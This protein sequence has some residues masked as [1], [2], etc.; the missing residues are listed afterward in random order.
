[1]LYLP[2]NREVVIRVPRVSAEYASADTLR[3]V[4]TIDLTPIAVSVSLVAFSPLWLQL[5]VSLPNLTAGE[6]RYEVRSGA[7]V[8]SRGLAIVE[9][10]SRGDFSADFDNAFL[11]DSEII[12]YNEKE[13]YIQYV[14]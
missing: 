1:M 10:E 11:K 12:S 4:G 9:R 8:V 7:R 6:Y 13:E 2:Q 5:A 14:E 3:L